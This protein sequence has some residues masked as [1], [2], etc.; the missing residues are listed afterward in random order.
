MLIMSSP[1]PA[2]R[3]EVIQNTADL[4]DIGA[5]RT[6]GG[7]FSAPFDELGPQPAIAMNGQNSPGDIGGIGGI[8]KQRSASKLLLR[9][10]NSRGHN[11]TTYREGL[12][13]R[14]IV[15]SEETG[16]DQRVGLSI[17]PMKIGFWDKAQV[18]NLRRQPK[19]SDG[20]AHMVEIPFIASG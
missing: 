18:V 9:P 1:A 12:Q 3:R 6:G 10:W 4:L 14:D 15:G 5:R 20:L 11:W 19:C 7:D 17:Q 8:E 16:E 13:G 2:D